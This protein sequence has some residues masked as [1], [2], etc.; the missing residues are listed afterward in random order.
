MSITILY[1]FR[2]IGIALAIIPLQ[3]AAMNALPNKLLSHG[4]AVV[5][6]T[7]QVAGSLGTAMLKTVMSTVANSNALNK[8]LAKTNINLYK[9]GMLDDA[10][11]GYSIL[12][13]Q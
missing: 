5:N 9:S 10:L 3:T 8:V 4:S 11:K 1:A 12:L 13:K 2:Y 7:K 6:T